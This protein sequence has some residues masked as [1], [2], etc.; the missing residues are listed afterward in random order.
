MNYWRKR[1]ILEDIL[2]LWGDSGGSR[3]RRRFPGKFRPQQH[4]EIP[5]VV[6]SQESEHM[7]HNR[8]RLTPFEDEGGSK[9]LQ[10]GFLIPRH[11]A[12]EN[13]RNIILAVISVFTQGSLPAVCLQVL[14][15][16]CEGTK[17]LPSVSDSNI[18]SLQLGIYPF[19][20]LSFPMIPANTFLL[21]HNQS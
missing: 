2:M 5:W 3:T 18:T 21:L 17:L 11:T 6:S 7:S 4:W 8:K 19:W 14:V 16:L 9:G 13:L 1:N 12:W 10:P 20:M 15:G